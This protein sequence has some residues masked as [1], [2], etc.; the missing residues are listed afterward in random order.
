MECNGSILQILYEDDDVVVINKPAGLTVHG[1]GKTKMVTLTDLILEKY[2]EME[3]VGEPQVLTHKGEVVTVL[4]PGIVH[5]LDRDTSGVLIIAKNQVAFEKL[6]EQ[7]QNR[8][9][10]KIYY[11][12]VYG[13]MKETKGII[14]T[15]IGRAPGGVRKWSA[16]FASR[17]T[18]RDARTEY[19][20]IKK[21]GGDP[22][23]REE[24]KGSTEDG[25]YSFVKLMPKTG[26][27]HQL[28]VHLKSINHP[29]VCDSLYAPNR[30]P[31]LGFTRLAL[32]A[33]S[34][35]ITLPSGKEGFFE[36]PLPEDFKNA[37]NLA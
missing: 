3:N 7:F 1:D 16:G 10:E 19:E 34:L 20:V 6:K 35:K 30:L 5:R 23:L 28:R 14:A 26:R 9:T 2:P 13:W 18:Q 25:T 11:G 8:T 17:G 33:A 31:A 37:P 22:D 36:A 21:L 32:H 29:L 24:G 27:T 15:P 4:R 12:Y